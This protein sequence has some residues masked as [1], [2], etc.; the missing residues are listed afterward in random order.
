MCDFLCDLPGVQA[1][2]SSK[3]QEAA[4]NA[5]VLS[6]ESQIHWLGEQNAQLTS[7][8]QAA[9]AAAASA[10]AAAGSAEGPGAAAGTAA[11]GGAA[12]AGAAASRGVLVGGAPHR[13]S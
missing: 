3:A 13:S 12:A 2:L 4:L 5:R 8:L 7:A 1:E 9:Q 6:L 11:G 10:P